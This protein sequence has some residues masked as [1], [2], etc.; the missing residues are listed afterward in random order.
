MR[1]SSRAFSGLVGLVHVDPRVLVPKVGYLKE[2]LVEAGLA[3]DVLEHGFVRPGRTAPDHD[4]IQL[5]GT[6]HC[7]DVLQGFQATAAPDPL[8]HHH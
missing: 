3:Q 5:F 7:H 4:P 1:I 2:V 8:G 6:N